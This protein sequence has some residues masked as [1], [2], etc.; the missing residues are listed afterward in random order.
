MPSS[1]PVNHKSFWILIGLSLTVLFWSVLLHLVTPNE[2]VSKIGVENGYIVMFL[3]ALIGGSS[4][5][6]S[7]SYIATVLTLAV[8]G[9]NPLW[10][11]LVSGVGL[12]MSDTIFFLIGRHSHEFITAPRLHLFIDKI[13][14]WLSRRSRYT[15]G[16]FIYLYTA[17]TPLPTDFVTVILGLARQPYML[18]ILPLI[19]GDFT[20]AYILATFGPK[21]LPF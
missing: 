4:T 12:S 8:G 13:A 11:A 18:V 3:V 10:L 5:F 19:L 17:F 9:L 1:K 21:F 7:V 14:L 6:S 20:Y 16:S 15:I 2:I